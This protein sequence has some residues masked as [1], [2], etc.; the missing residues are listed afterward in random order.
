MNTESCRI[1][2]CSIMEAS[3]A[4]LLLQ[5]KTSQL[6]SCRTDVFPEKLLKVGTAKQIELK[7]KYLKH[8]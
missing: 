1:D 7:K 6:E 3:S 4:P 5:G 8:P 2:G